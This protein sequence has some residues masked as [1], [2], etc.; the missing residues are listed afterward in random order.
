M[1]RGNLVIPVPAAE[2]RYW[3]RELSWHFDEF[4]K[5]GSLSVDELWDD[6]E[7]MRRQLWVVKNKAAVLTTIQPDN[8]KTCVVTHA[9]GR[10]MR[11]WVHLWS[12]LEDWARGI[13]C[14]RIE[15]VAR[16]GWERVL[17]DMT[18]T[19]VILEKRL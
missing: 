8:F 16:P 2:A 15:A 4:C 9:A 5:D 13:G 7:N 14:Q 18:K 19:H 6:I 10:Q 3:R 12:Y 1:G 17:R 11:D